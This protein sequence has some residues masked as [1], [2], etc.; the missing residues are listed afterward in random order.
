MKLPFKLY[1]K[2]S[3]SIPSGSQREISSIVFYGTLMEVTTVMSNG[4]YNEA[5]FRIP[6]GT[7][8]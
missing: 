5:S 3:V 8:R 2:L 1:I 4:N 7:L 6:R